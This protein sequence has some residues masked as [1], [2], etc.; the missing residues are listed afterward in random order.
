M[1]TRTK[2]ILRIVVTLVILGLTVLGVWLIWFKPSNELEIF[3]NLTNLQDSNEK[4]FITARSAVQSRNYLKDSSDLYRFMD[5]K[6]TDSSQKIQGQ[7]A[8]HRLYMFGE[9][10]NAGENNPYIIAR[11]DGAD[12]QK[13]ATVTGKN[14]L[15]PYLGL[16]KM[17]DAIDDAFE[18][19][20]SYVQLAENVDTEDVRNINGLINSLKTNYDGFTSLQVN[21]LQ[22]LLDSLT[23]ENQPTILNQVCA[24]YENLF[25]QYFKIVESYAD[26][27]LGLKNFVVEYVFDG[28][29]TFDEEI[30]YHDVALNAIENWADQSKAANAHGVA[31]YKV[32]RK[33]DKNAPVVNDNST[34][35]IYSADVANVLYA[36]DYEKNALNTEDFRNE[37]PA[38]VEAYATLAQKYSSPLYGSLS[39]FKLAN[40]KKHELYNITTETD[41]E[42]S[43]Q[44]IVL[45]ELQSKY[46]ETHLTRVR[47]VLNHFFRL[48]NKGVNA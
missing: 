2:I 45:N 24:I 37:I 31:S 46:D 34:Y 14:H 13:Y 44:I 21:E 30:V 9:L 20:Y 41:P 22:K 15:N 43:D 19:Y 4:S 23:S 38:V 1:S 26:L 39:I 6:E 29:L 33:D 5:F 48:S 7:I 3:Q 12:T 17:Y 8:Y 42:T 32:F 25:T 47:L 40:E 27:T 36:C 10:T 16:N 11:T 35:I 28:T 18:Y